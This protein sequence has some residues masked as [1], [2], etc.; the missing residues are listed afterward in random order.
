[1][2]RGILMF[3][4]RKSKEEAVKVLMAL[5]IVAIMVGSVVFAFVLI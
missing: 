1:M 5:F 4:S 3:K 2:N